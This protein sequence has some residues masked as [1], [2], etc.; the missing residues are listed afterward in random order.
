MGAG[1]REHFPLLHTAERGDR[2]CAGEL[3][4]RVFIAS[5]FSLLNLFISILFC[6]NSGVWDSLGGAVRN[7]PCFPPHGDKAFGV[8]AF[9]N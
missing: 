2:V 9:C 7:Q 5:A 6:I 1:V 4:P 3:K 8:F